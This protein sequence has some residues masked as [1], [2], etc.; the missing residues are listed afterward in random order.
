M[1]P[2]CG[3]PISKKLLRPALSYRALLI[4]AAVILIC[5]YLALTVALDNFEEDLEDLLE[6]DDEEPFFEAPEMIRIPA[7]SFQMSGPA[8]EGIISSTHYQR[9]VTITRPFLISKTEITQRLWLQV[10]GRKAGFFNEC[11]DKNPVETV[12]W[13]EAVEFCN[14]LS[15]MDGLNPC[16]L[17]NG[18]DVAWT[19]CT[20]YRLPTEAEW[21]YAARGGSVEQFNTPEQETINASEMLPKECTKCKA[22]MGPKIVGC[23]PPNKFGLQ[24]MIGNVFEWCW[25]W[26]EEDPDS[27]P[28]IDPEG[29]A[30]GKRHVIRGGG[31]CEPAPSCQSAD[32][33]TPSPHM[34]SN[35]LGFR[36]V[37]F[38]Y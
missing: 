25:D 6:D 24:D 5:F 21:E 8:W 34:R 35:D 32:R 7:G 37:R 26:Y 1:C 12:S 9:Q 31:W 14:R 29:P 11:G 10:M 38:T 19:S 30:S 16:Y 2:G 27:Q 22:N 33:L 28:K 36:V 3:R 4:Q 13:Y 18:D 23:S 15:D 20:G 17:I